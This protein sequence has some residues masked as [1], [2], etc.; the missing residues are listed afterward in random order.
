MLT[1]R[2]AVLIASILALCAVLLLAHEVASW[3][4]RTG[5]PDKALHDAVKRQALQE[6][7]ELL[8][9]GFDTEGRDD[10]GDTVLLI[11]PHDIEREL[12]KVFAN[13]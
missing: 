4:D 1:K 11:G 3:L 8:A 5:Y 9:I 2:F 13:K 7:S 6:L 10:H 12:K